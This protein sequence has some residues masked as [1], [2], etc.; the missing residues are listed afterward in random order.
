MF[1]YVLLALLLAVS[2]TCCCHGLPPLYVSLFSQLFFF[3]FRIYFKMSSYFRGGGGGSRRGR[4]AGGYR[5]GSGGRGGAFSH[6][7]GR[8]AN[9]DGA[10]NDMA[11]SASVHS[12]MGSDCDRGAHDVLGE[13]LS[14]PP[15]GLSCSALIAFLQ[16]VEGCNYSQ[17]KNL[18]GKTFH[19][20]SNTMPD[21]SAVTVRFLRIQPDPF[22]PGSQLQVTVPAPFS[23]RA[24]LRS[25]CSTPPQHPS[26]SATPEKPSDS[27]TAAVSAEDASWR[28]VAA[29]DYLLRCLHRELAHQQHSSF[30]IQLLPMSQH[31]LPRS[32]VQVVESESGDASEL[33]DMP[34]GYIHV[35]LR[36]KLP[37]HARRI[38]GRGIHRILFSELLP[39]FQHAILRC[40]HAALW[41]H[42]T[43]VSDQVWL[44]QQ[45]RSAGLVAFIANG[46]V[47]PR[48]AGD[49][50]QPLADTTVVAF[51]A[52]P[53]LL[54]TFH[55]PFSQRVITGAGLPHGLTLIA[56]GGFHGKSTLLRALE[57]G[58]YNHV[59]DDGRAFVV[60]DPTAVKIRAEDRRSVQGV[61]ISPFIRN[62]PHRKD[63]TF[64]STS[65]ASGSTSQAANIMEA[66]ELGST[67]LLLDED[68]SATNFMFRDALM[69]QLVPPAEEPI[70]SFVRRVRDLVQRHQVS[71]VMVVGG[72]GQYFPMADTVLVMHAYHVRDATAQAREIVRQNCTADD[73]NSHQNSGINAGGLVEG[74][75]GGPLTQATSA[76]PLP[77]QRHFNWDLTF[78]SLVNSGRR[79]QGGR[80]KI[81][82]VGTERVRVGHEE[83]ELSLVEQLVEEGQLNA[84]AQCLAMLYDEGSAS[85]EK[86]QRG[87][88]LSPPH[89][90]PLWTPS[91]ASIANASHSAPARLSPVSDYCQL[92]RNCESRLRL[93]R[94]ELQTPSCY[95]A[96]GFTSLPRVFELGAA[97]NRL[98]TLAT[99]H[100]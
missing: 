17:L 40:R 47:L 46:A 27:S 65:D 72:S 63:T 85:A 51:T 35:F 89:P 82:A 76:F 59:P 68:T 16:D 74:A 96:T 97:L 75:A 54:Q 36:V 84:I 64:F 4:S 92:V 69:E 86:L 13:H 15:P 3:F 83:I 52:P 66:L 87:P 91:A 22:A 10:V 90:P 9:P 43:S 2:P 67:A 29:E 93:A 11:D 33:Q 5:G 21:P 34:D 98:R 42:V 30:A 18:T 1:F 78:A 94:L 39:L 37:G 62:L 73:G 95:L 14:R 79:G 100:K 6:G 56:G 44:R 99:L 70:I 23:T 24:L 88:L 12:D 50:D 41:E 49:T 81:G 80:V 20:T 19:L 48:V 31:V 8:Y 26:L 71:V 28:R 53:S 61:D 25:G 32:T 60:T 55:L 38:D 7:G 45:L 57:V 58:V 77:P